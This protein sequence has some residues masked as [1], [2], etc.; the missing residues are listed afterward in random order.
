MIDTAT[1]LSAGAQRIVELLNRYLDARR[2]T[3]AQRR[4][5]LRDLHGALLEVDA[6]YR[7]LFTALDESLE[8]LAAEPDRAAAQ[9][10]MREA[11]R[12]LR[13]EREHYDAARTSIRALSRNLM[14]FTEDAATRYYL[15]AVVAYMLDEDPG[16][17]F[18][19]NV[20][21]AVSKLVAR[22]IGALTRTPSSVVLKALEDGR[23]PDQV[24]ALLRERRQQMKRFLDYAI[25]QYTYLLARELA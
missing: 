13:A 19:S 1:L 14:L 8:A 21:A 22:D 7:R 6:D 16:I 25:E 20:P 2:A 10:A 9:R 11:T 12:K 4:E 17:G 18:P 15:W 3:R 5:L 24:L 23:T